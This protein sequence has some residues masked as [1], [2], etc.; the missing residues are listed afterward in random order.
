V[1][2]A[3]RNGSVA[4][5]HT[6]VDDQEFLRLRSLAFSDAVDGAHLQQLV[7]HI[8]PQDVVEGSCGC[9]VAKTLCQTL[10]MRQEVRN[11]QPQ[12]GVY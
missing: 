12:R 9:I 4:Q 7:E 6:F 1:G 2:R 10:D 3:G 5:C 11:A 8:F